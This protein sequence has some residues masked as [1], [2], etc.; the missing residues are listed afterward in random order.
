[1]C[2]WRNSKSAAKSGTR[3]RKLENDIDALCRCQLRCASGNTEQESI[4]R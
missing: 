3:I 4:F 2:P 1:M